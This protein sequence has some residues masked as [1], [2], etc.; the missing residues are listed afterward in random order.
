M[1]DHCHDHPNY[2]WMAVRRVEA[3]TEKVKQKSALSGEPLTSLIRT[4]G[5]LRSGMGKHYGVAFTNPTFHRKNR[6][7]DGAPADSDSLVWPIRLLR[8]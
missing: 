6:P 3:K 1:T 7:P 4:S 5:E 2:A 8:E